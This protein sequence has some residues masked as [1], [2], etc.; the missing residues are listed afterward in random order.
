MA[1]SIAASMPI[2]AAQPAPPGPAR[3]DR[4]PVCGMFVAKYPDFVCVVVFRDGARAYFD[5]AK[6]LFK[7]VFN[8]GKY[9]PRRKA[10]DIADIYVTDYYRLTLVDGR[11]AHYV[12]GSDV[13]GP[14]GKE[15][16]PFGGK[17]EAQEFLEDHQGRAIVTYDAVSPAMIRSLD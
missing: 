14:M 2:Q 6:D 4:C 16:V 3:T 8:P 1:I 13:Y 12:V 17:A 5:G 10:E 9:D 11:K 15:L 7:Y